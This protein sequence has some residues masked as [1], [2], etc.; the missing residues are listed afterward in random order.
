MTASV[1]LVLPAVIALIN[2]AGG[3]CRGA[4][5]GEVNSH[6]I[7]RDGYIIGKIVFAVRARPVIPIIA[8][9]FDDYCL[10]GDLD[11]T[12]CL[13]PVLDCEGNFK[14]YLAVSGTVSAF[15]SVQILDFDNDV[16][17]PKIV[18]I[19]FGSGI[20]AVKFP[21]FFNRCSFKEWRPLAKVFKI[22][23]SRLVSYH[24]ILALGGV[25]A[26]FGFII[27]HKAVKIRDLAT[28][29]KNH[30]GRIGNGVHY[31]GNFAFGLEFFGGSITRRNIN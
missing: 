8:A 23:L 21:K 13:A 7:F 5:L 24:N 16:I 31:N 14:I 10:D 4:A 2:M 26:Y 28:F 27:Q 19:M 12:S 20:I 3:G 15:K 29:I 18:E 22:Q 30:F 11:F 9:L 25:I 17:W 6:I 1:R